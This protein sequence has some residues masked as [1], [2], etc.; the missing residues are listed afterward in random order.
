MYALIFLMGKRWGGVG[1]RC[2]CFMIVFL[3]I[4]DFEFV[5]PVCCDFDFV[6]KESICTKF[7]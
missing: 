2:Y 3:V 6:A 1:G 5:V 4:V 7:H